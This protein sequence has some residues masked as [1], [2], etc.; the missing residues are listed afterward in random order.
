MLPRVTG[1][2]VWAGPG[3]QRHGSRLDSP[4]QHEGPEVQDLGLP[5]KL[6]LTLSK[7]RR[8]DCPWVSGLQPSLQAKPRCSVCSSAEDRGA[9]VSEVPA[10]SPADDGVSLTVKVNDLGLPRGPHAPPTGS[11]PVVGGVRAHYFICN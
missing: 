4:K 7:R 11:G 1:T 2:L 10:A 9:C 6:H 5:G 8:S 3:D